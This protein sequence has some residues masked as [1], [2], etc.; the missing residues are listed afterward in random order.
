MAAYKDEQRGTWYVS[1]HYYDWTGKNCR[2]VKRGFK[3]KRE[4]TEWE[5]HFRMKEAADLDMTF[6]E[7]VEAY[8]R[9]MKPKL[10]HNTWLT[11]EHILRTK[12][13]PY[14][15]DKKMR[16]IR[17]TDIIQWQN[18]QISYRDAKGKP[19]APTYLKTLQSELSA[20]FNHA[21]RFYEL[22]SNPVV[23]AGSL[24]K[25]KA[26]EMLFW[27]KEEYLKF[28]E[29]VK[30]KPY[31][32]HAFQ[33]LYWCGLRVGELLALTPQ[34]I[35]FDNKVIRVTKSYQRLEGKD[36]IT[37]P[38]TPKSKRNVSMPDFL[39]EELKDYIG[40]LYGILPTDR[41]F[42]LTKSFL[43]HE[44]TRGAEKAGV[45]RIRIHDLRHSHVSLL[46]SMG[47][48]NIIMCD[49]N[50][51]IC[52]GDSGLNPGQEEISHISN[53]LK[54]HGLLADAM[55]GADAFIGVSR[56]G[57]V[58]KEMVASMNQ[59]IVFAM[60]N[61][62]PE[63]MPDEARKGGA[64]VIATGRSDFPNQ[65]NNVL[66]FPGVFRGAF[67]VRA[68]DINEEMKI[69]AAKAIAEL[70]SDEELSEDNIIPKAFDK[71]VGPAVAKAVAEAARKTGVARK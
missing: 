11:K 17:A 43:H 19:Y 53:Q 65:I 7:F 64:R 23:K 27:T 44:M 22:K 42:H 6:G 69:A 8:T 67:D 2:K 26:E 33:I 52:E 68:S 60:A 37:D 34:D 70:I 55:K 18:E 57:L 66:V 12:L 15:K 16:D 39:C 1:F 54:E 3:T 40:R 31:S 41:I 9:D 30:D 38:K 58:S 46:I 49:I 10:K 21:V 45:K 48:G 61:P 4:A 24:G 56:P 35:D 25:G 71:R 50:G 5:R 47:F 59:G 51:I 13:L 28:I 36:V 32:Y 29:A 63:I 62:T 14:F 20:L